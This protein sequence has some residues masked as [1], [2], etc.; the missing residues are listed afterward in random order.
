M[1]KIIGACAI[2]VAAGRGRRFGGETPKQFAVVAGR[3]LLAWT[4]QALHEAER[5][6]TVVVVLPPDCLGLFRDF[7]IPQCSSDKV[8]ASVP[9]G[10]ER[11]DSVMAG[12]EA[13]PAE[14]SIVAVHDG[15]RPLIEPGLINRLIE[16]AAGGTCAVPGVK[17]R[18]TV[19]RCNADGFVMETIHRDGLVEVQTPQVFPLDTLVAAYTRVKKR[20]GW[21]DDAQVVEAAGIPVY[22]ENGAPW[23]IKVTFPED[24]AMVSFW[25]ERMYKE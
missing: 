3:P 9:G 15:V 4:L 1:D 20:H 10:G 8:I 22:V 14:T 21:T 24:L 17:L 6:E 12:L 11:Y 7:V 2:V 19:K 13:L 16:L 18:S 23:N 25:L 5:V